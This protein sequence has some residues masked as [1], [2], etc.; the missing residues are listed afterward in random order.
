M[1]T[2]IECPSLKLEGLRKS[3]PTTHVRRP[4]IRYDYDGRFVC[5]MGFESE[6]VAGMSSTPLVLGS[7]WVLQDWRVIGGSHRDERHALSCAACS[8]QGEQGSGGIFVASLWLSHANDYRIIDATDETPS[9][10]C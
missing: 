1:L 6:I 7:M 3:I 8:G 4:L 5:V 10:R 2:P 9:R